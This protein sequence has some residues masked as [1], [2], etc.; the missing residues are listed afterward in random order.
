MARGGLFRYGA[1]IIEEC[2]NL[3]LA[4]GDKFWSAGGVEP[5]IVGAGALGLW[6]F[7]KPSSH[8]GQRSHT[9]AI[10]PN[11]VQFHLTSP[12]GPFDPQ[13]TKT[14]PYDASGAIWQKAYDAR[15]ADLT[16]PK[17]P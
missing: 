6:E 5:G 8:C 14:A 17:N 1:C 2:L 3:L 10:W 11:P 4:L 12:V 9:T 13:T 16:M 7:S 15:T